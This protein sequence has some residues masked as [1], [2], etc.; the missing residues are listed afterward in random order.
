[1]NQS[2]LLTKAVAEDLDVGV[3]RVEVPAP[4]GGYVVGNQINLSTFAILSQSSW[5]PGTVAAGSYQST[6]VTVDGASLGAPCLAS[7]T[8]G[9]AVGLYITAQVSAANTVAVA[10]HNATGSDVVVNASTLSVLVFPIP[11]V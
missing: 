4:S 6:S 3:S 9:L 7:L 8:V 2:I 5:T 1:M 10:V 11:G